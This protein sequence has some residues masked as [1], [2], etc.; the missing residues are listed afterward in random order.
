M[1]IPNF[2]IFILMLTLFGCSG[3]VETTKKIWGSSTEAL[4]NARVDAISQKFSCSFDEC[5]ELVLAMK[6]KKAKVTL[7]YKAPGYLETPQPIEPEKKMDVTVGSD[8]VLNT[9]PTED[10]GFFDIFIQD[11]I[12]GMIIVYGIEGNVN[13]TEVG[14]FFSS[15]SSKTTKIEV[16]SLSSSAKEKIA[17]YVFNY[18]NKKLLSPKE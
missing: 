3:V 8:G 16:T 1:N 11:R 14:I 10:E 17:E 12:K 5:F 4:E 6:H 13:T 2:S 7:Q 18:L 9:Q 15:I